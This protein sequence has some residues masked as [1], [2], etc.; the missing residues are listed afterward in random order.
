MF[1]SILKDYLIVFKIQNVII[2]TII[3]ARKEDEKSS[4]F[5]LYDSNDE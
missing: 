5:S 1:N 2:D 3:K 4:T